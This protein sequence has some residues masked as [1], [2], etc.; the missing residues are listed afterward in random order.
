MKIVVIGQFC[1][2]CYGSIETQLIQE[3]GGILYALY[4]L[5]SVTK[6]DDIIYPVFPID[7]KIALD[8]TSNNSLLP[9]IDWR[10]VYPTEDK[11]TSILVSTN[12][13]NEM[14]FKA[15]HVLNEPIKPNQLPEVD[16]DIVYLNFQTGF[17][18]KTDDLE[19]LRK[20]Y[21]GAYIHIDIHLLAKRIAQSH[22]GNQVNA[23]SDLQKIFSAA[24]SVQMN[25]QELLGLIYA[26]GLTEKELVKK[27]LLDGSV[28]AFIITKGER[29]VVCYEKLLNKIETHVLRPTQTISTENT[30]G[31]GDVLGAVMTYELQK[32]KGFRSA[33]TRGMRLAELAASKKGFQAKVEH[34]RINGA[35]MS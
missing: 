34:V 21:P 27:A 5:S 22:K 1:H 9:N 12:S 18:I 14:E 33:L 17:E 6:K 13:Q 15:I 28:K 19:I 20:K 26:S 35:L 4:A 24:D 29:G 10:F 30:I 8:L 23:V 32:T 16:A 31:C 7:K 11:N 3:P 2:D 25:Q